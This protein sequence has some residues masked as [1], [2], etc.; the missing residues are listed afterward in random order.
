[1][2]AISAHG[3]VVRIKWH[4]GDDVFPAVKLLVIWRVSLYPGLGL[5]SV[6][7]L[8]PPYN[9]PTGDRKPWSRRDCKAAVVWACWLKEARISD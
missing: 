6:A 1:M 2:R 8:C 4:N 3:V 5:L 7:C 9:F